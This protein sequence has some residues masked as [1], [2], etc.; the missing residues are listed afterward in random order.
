MKSKKVLQYAEA[1]YSF[2]GSR[3]AHLGLKLRAA[4]FPLLRF[5]HRVSF[6]MIARSLNFCPEFGVHYTVDEVE[7]NIN[8]PRAKTKE[9]EPL[10]KPAENNP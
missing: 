3:D 1:I 2:H 5:A 4:L 7:R 6:L 10:A 9:A 8:Q